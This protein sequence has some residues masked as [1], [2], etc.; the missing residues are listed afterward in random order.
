MGNEK[1]PIRC[2]ALL[3]D[4]VQGA[5]HGSRVQ[6]LTALTGTHDIVRNTRVISKSYLFS[7]FQSYH[8]A[9]V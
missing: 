5:V 6:Y 7:A 8:I 4:A 9:V 3:H 1:P 2:L